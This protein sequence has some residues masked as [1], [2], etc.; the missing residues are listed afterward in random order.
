MSPSTRT[1]LYRGRVSHA[2]TSPATH[3]FSYTTY[4]LALDLD[5]LDEARDTQRWMPVLGVERAA[6]LSFRRR[7]YLG[8]ASRPLKES[9]L[10][11]VERDLGVRPGGRVVLLTHVRV[12]GFVFNPVS[13]Y[14]CYGGDGALAA[15]VAEITNTPWRE[16]HAYALRARDGKIEATFAKGFHVSPF[17]SMAQRYAWDLSPMGERI[18]VAMENQEEGA[19][20]FAAKLVLNREPLTRAALARAAL[21]VPLIGL[22]V[23]V[24]IYWQALLLLLKGAPRF[25]HPKSA[26]SARA[27]REW[28]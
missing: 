27:K 13:F 15:V 24:S 1:A 2:R 5:E 25:T 22:K 10:D 21:A 14:Y 19:R 17:M 8:E 3:A 18:T 12:L 26:G 9:I 23:L 28:S 4:M 7:D 16:R 11:V 20:V 6:P